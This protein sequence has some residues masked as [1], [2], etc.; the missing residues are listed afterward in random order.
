MAPRASTS[1]QNHTHR[2][3]FVHDVEETMR[4]CGEIIKLIGY[5]ADRSNLNTKLPAASATMQDIQPELH[6]QLGVNEQTGIVLW[7]K[8][9]LHQRL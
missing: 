5:L 9:T 8:L 2:D 6:A 1:T 7:P 4:G 3:W